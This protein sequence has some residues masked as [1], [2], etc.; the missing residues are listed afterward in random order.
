M[1]KQH[2]ILVVLALAAGVGIGAL[3]LRP[4]AKTTQTALPEV[5]LIDQ[6]AHGV[7][8]ILIRVDKRVR[9]RG[10]AMALAKLAY[11]AIRGGTPFADVAKGRSDD[12]SAPD[13]GFLGFVPAHHETSFS[14]AVQAL[15][16]G[17]VSPP[18]WTQRGWMIVK[19]HTFEE[20]VDLERTLWIPTHGFYVQYDGMPLAK[21]RTKEQ[22]FQLASEALE[23]IRA[24]QMTLED[25]RAQFSDEP[26]PPPEA[27]LR[28]TANRPHSRVAYDALKEAKVGE[29]IGP[30]D[31][32]EGWGVLVRG[33]YLRS[34]M[35]HILIQHARSRNRAQ[36][37]RRTP[38]QAKELAD[39]VLREALDAPKTWDRLV[40]RYSDDDRGRD[41][42]GAM[43]VMGPGLMPHGFEKHLY[44]TPPG[45][46]CKHVIESPFGYHIVWRVN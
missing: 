3:L 40:E 10:D 19:R 34:F 1:K 43:G 2:T 5:P 31:A 4:Q 20:T 45:A 32:N 6:M 35:R 41:M 9:E 21:G 8:N 33:R 37:V 17:Q 26:E 28:M 7:S 27:F 11:E 29:L 24:G 15:H 14:G 23:R 46:I 16:P 44:D 12:A 42:D 25:A 30:V 13:G 22:A 18:L 38:Q 39:T 36:R